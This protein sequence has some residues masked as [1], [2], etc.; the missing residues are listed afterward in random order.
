MENVPRGET[1][2]A[3]LLGAQ[4]WPEYPRLNVENSA[5]F[6]NSSRRF[7]EYL[8]SSQGMHLPPAQVL[9]LFDSP[10]SASDMM[11][12]IVDFLKLIPKSRCA[13]Q[14]DVI[15]HYVGHGDLVD[16]REQ[17]YH[18][19]IRSTREDVV[20]T[21]SLECNELT[22]QLHKGARTGRT[23]LILDACYSGMARYS[24]QSSDEAHI[25]RIRGQALPR[26]GVAILCSSSEK[27]RSKIPIGAA[28]TM[29]SGALLKVL[30]SPDREEEEPLS[31]RELAEEVDE[32]IQAEFQDDAVR[33]QQHSTVQGDGDVATVPLFRRLSRS[34]QLPRVRFLSPRAE[35]RWL[36]GRSSQIVWK[37]EEDRDQNCIGAGLWIEVELW[38]CASEI[39]PHDARGE[40][41][42]IVREVVYA[43][44]HKEIIHSWIPPR[45]LSQRAR[46]RIEARVI[47]RADLSIVG[48][49]APFVIEDTPVPTS[50]VQSESIDPAS[51]SQP[52]SSPSQGGSVAE[53]TAPSLPIRVSP[54]KSTPD[55]AL[56]TKSGSPVV[57]FTGF[58]LQF[59]F[60]FYAVLLEK[61]VYSWIGSLRTSL[62]EWIAKLPDWAESVASVV[63]DLV[64]AGVIGVVSLCLFMTPLAVGLAFVWIESL[65]VKQDKSK[66][67]VLCLGAVGVWLG[68]ILGSP[69]LGAAY[70]GGL[71][72]VILAGLAIEVRSRWKT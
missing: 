39:E 62:N 32:L 24:S 49:S 46:Y 45:G 10:M 50:T 6:A 61:S 30:E 48:T 29:F 31:I 64:G 67:L 56:D 33:P 52:T 43:P 8:L 7:K 37:F 2:F 28:C 60:I 11:I 9:D 19:M 35:D 4:A 70:I 68:Y 18:L 58:G 42:R 17:R 38:L 72:G 54:E 69:L 14:L 40:I 26:R 13:S 36:S 5:A 53:V 20:V 12:A 44:P 55:R 3:I 65:V 41:T 71:L 21:T 23:Y 59:A 25:R 22:R 34:E 47:S 15:L 1:T 51:T 63:G 57:F 27:S 66:F 16:S